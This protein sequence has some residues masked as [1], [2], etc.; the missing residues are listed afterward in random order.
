[1]K[2]RWARELY[3]KPL[4]YSITNA[5]AIYKLKNQQSKLGV[6]NE[7]PTTLSQI[8]IKNSFQRDQTIS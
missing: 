1:M 5:N 4:N 2:T 6:F 3:E 8:L 7:W